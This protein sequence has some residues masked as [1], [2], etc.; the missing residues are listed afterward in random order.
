MAAEYGWS[1]IA[2]RLYALW[3]MCALVKWQHAN[4]GKGWE[5]SNLLRHVHEFFF[6]YPTILEYFRIQALF[7][8]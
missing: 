5:E 6:Q 1:S 8:K 4:G 3:E 2:M 7:G